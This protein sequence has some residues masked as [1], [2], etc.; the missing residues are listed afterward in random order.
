MD[1]NISPDPFVSASQTSFDNHSVDKEGISSLTETDRS[2]ETERSSS[3]NKTDHP[4]WN[5]YLLSVGRSCI[6]RITAGLSLLKQAVWSTYR[7][8]VAFLKPDKTE[9]YPTQPVEKEYSLFLAKDEAINNEQSVDGIDERSNSDPTGIDETKYSLFP[10]KGQ[11]IMG[12]LETDGYTTCSIPDS[13]SFK[14]GSNLC[15]RIADSLLVTMD[16]LSKTTDASTDVKESMG[17]TQ[18]HVDITRCN[19]LTI[20]DEEGHQFVILQKSEEERGGYQVQVSKNSQLVRQDDIND[21][22]DMEKVSDDLM[23]RLANEV[24]TL[25]GLNNIPI[26]T[27]IIGILNQT[28]GNTTVNQISNHRVVKYRDGTSSDL[29]VESA[30]GF[31]F[32]KGGLDLH[33][34][35]KR[36]GSLDDPDHYFNLT[37]DA[38]SDNCNFLLKDK[39]EGASFISLPDSEMKLH[40]LFSV[41]IK[42][43][44]NFD[45]TKEQS[46]DNFPCSLE[47]SE[48]TSVYTTAASRSRENPTSMLPE[49]V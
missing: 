8:T 47:V 3:L 28:L 37:F 13:G 44:K 18:T 12:Q 9:Y 38:K 25:V 2:S 11:V 31:P 21:T 32:P 48:F 43:N 20:S 10:V 16:Y 6:K 19:S 30:I 39:V 14:A 24:Y 1:F 17:F 23:N 40:V 34:D 15:H 33:Y 36:V 22:N 7:A 4:G 49:T 46:L 26:A 27:A 35:L 41:K 29:R 45:T 5:F 42:P